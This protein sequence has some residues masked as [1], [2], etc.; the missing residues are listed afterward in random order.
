MFILN[1]RTNK[2]PISIKWSNEEEL[3]KWALLQFGFYKCQKNDFLK[4]F[5]DMNNFWFNQRFEM[6]AFNLP[7]SP[8]IMDIGCG[9]STIDLLLYSYIPD[10][11]Y[12]LVDRDGYFFKNKEAVALFTGDPEIPLDINFF[13]K[14]VD[15]HGYGKFLNEKINFMQHDEL[16]PFYNSWEPVKDAIKTSEFDEKR[17]TML[18]PEDSFPEDVDLVMS[19]FSWCWHYSKSKY[20]NKVFP[21]LKKG[22][23]LLLDCLVSKQDTT[24]QEISEEMKCKPIKYPLNFTNTK[25][26][27]TY[28]C[29]W[30]KRC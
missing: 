28:R 21:S 15:E 26:L 22:G 10:S 3:Y 2:G 20:W 18:S 1:V 8:K 24:I 27:F 29:L 17:F 4:M 16:Y 13:E 7:N 6:K 9:V 14:F 23:K 19:S 5:S 12:W 25:E 30:E 11:K